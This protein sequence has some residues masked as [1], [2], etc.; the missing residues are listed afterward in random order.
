M[1]VIPMANPYATELPPYSAAHMQNVARRRW[2]A[3]QDR[4]RKLKR[5]QDADHLVDRVS[6]VRRLR[7]GRAAAS[8]FS[9]VYNMFNESFFRAR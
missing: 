3:Q 4:E 8:Q 2:M 9:P 5:V 6:R 1:N 7:P